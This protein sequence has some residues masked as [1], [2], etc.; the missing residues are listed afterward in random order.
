VLDNSG[1]D[2]ATAAIAYAKTGIAM[3]D[4]VLICWRSKYWYNVIRP[5]TYI[6]EYI[7]PSWTPLIV[8]PPHPEYPSGHSVIT[9]SFMQVMT[10]LFGNSYSFTDNTYGTQFGG[11]RTYSSFNAAADEC[12]QSRFYGGIHYQNAIQ[13]GLRVGRKLGRSVGRLDL[14]TYQ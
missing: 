1:A 13:E 10:A 9:G 12:A 3:H 11:A 2:L 8:T 14:L 7:D 5:I 4:A 6:N